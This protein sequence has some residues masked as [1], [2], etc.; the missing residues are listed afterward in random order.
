MQITG[1]DAPPSAREE[2]LMSADSLG[3]QSVR[4]NGAVLQAADDGTIP[5][6]EPHVVKP[7]SSSPAIT[8]APLTY[9]FFVL[10]GVEARACK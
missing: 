2:Y 4:L 9:G 3:S 10:R 8:L 1:F 6:L 5:P 7:A